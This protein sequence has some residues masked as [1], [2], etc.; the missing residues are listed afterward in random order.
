MAQQIAYVFDNDG[1]L[2]NCLPEFERAITERMIT[3]LARMASISAEQILEKRRELFKRHNIHSTLLVFWRE[4]I[5]QDT[6]DFIKKTYLAIDPLFYGVRRN[7]RLREALL[8]LDAPLYVHTNNP[9]AFAKNIFECIGIEDLFVQIFGMFENNG[10]QKPDP[11]AFQNLQLAVSSYKVRW[12]AD[13]E[14]ANLITAK[15][16]GF[17]TIAVGDENLI[18]IFPFT[19]VNSRSRI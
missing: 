3:L 5:I 19:F 9:S 4:G 18:L 16:L 6:E 14:E 15:N 11:R 2:Y 12:Y 10:Y 17:K 8:R 1:T 7:D 13:N